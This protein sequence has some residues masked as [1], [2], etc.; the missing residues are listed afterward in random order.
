M[1]G[2]VETAL[3]YALSM[4]LAALVLA[5]SGQARGPCER[6]ARTTEAGLTLRDIDCGQGRIATG[7][8]LVDVSYRASIQG[9]SSRSGGFRFVLGAGQVISGLD[10]GVAG[11]RVGG[12]RR[13]VVPP[14]LA[15]GRSGVEGLAPPR[16][17]VVYIVRLRAVEQR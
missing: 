4:T 17:T 13:L 15:Y 16:S 10:Q 9:G 12:T 2:G 3:R 1:R 6:T 8:D 14:E 7:S 11:M 5:C